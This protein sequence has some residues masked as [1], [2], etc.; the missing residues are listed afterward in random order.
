MRNQLSTHRKDKE[1]NLENIKNA[2]NQA[3]KQLITALNEG[4]SESLT[5]CVAAIGRFHRCNLLNVMVVL[6]RYDE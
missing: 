1:M 5:H 6:A 4:R 2:T 3:T